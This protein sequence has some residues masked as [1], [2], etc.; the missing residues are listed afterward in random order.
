M[1]P[2]GIKT[3]K[4]YDAEFKRNAVELVLSRQRSCRSVERDLAIPQGVL[5]RWL[6]EYREDP[7]NSFPG[8]WKRK[9]SVVTVEPSLLSLKQ[10]IEQLRLERDILKKALAIV[11]RDPV[12]NMRLLVN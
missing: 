9:A 4:K 5:S 6:R 10:E 3:R 8:I 11:S 12:K 7:K 1:K 2:E